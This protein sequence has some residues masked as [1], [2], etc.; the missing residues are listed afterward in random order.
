MSK[1]KIDALVEGGKASAA[2]PLGPALG[3]LQVNIGEVIAEINRKTEPFKGMKVPVKVIVDTDTKEFEIEVG[4]PPTSQLIK[5]ELEIELGSGAA[6]ENKVGNLAVEQAVK[7]ATMKADAMLANDFKSAVKTVI[8]S[9]QSMG[10]MVEGKD[11]K[12]VEK[13]I[14]EGKYDD[15]INNK[16]TEVPAEKAEKLKSELAVRQQA[17]ANVSAKRKAEQ[18]AAAEAAEKKAEAKKAQEALAKAKG[19]VK[20]EDAKP[21]KK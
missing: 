2:P 21:A 18:Q 1:E 5:K 10:I 12:E 20:K 7:I 17:Y 13:E 14:D 16:V 9:C 8:G 6:H 19:P 15:I 4:T 3:P 11:A